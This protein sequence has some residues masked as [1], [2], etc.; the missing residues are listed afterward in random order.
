MPS[1]RSDGHRASPA[2]VGALL[3]TCVLL[4]STLRAEVVADSWSDWSSSGTQGENGWWNGYYNLTRDPG[5]TYQVRDFIPFRNTAG[6]GGGAVSPTGNHWTGSSWD[7]LGAASGPWTALGQESTHPNGTNSAPSEEHWTIRRW[8][9]DRALPG[10]EITWHMRKT[11]TNGGNGVTGILFVNGAQVDRA[12]IAG[13]DGVGVMRT[14]VRNIAVDDVIDLALTPEGPDRQRGDGSDGSAYRLTIDDAFR[15]ADGDGITDGQDNCPTVANA[16][17][18]DRDGDGA[19][20]A[21]DNCPDDANPDQRDFNRNGVGDACDA[22]VSPRAFDIA[23]NEIHY[24]PV[25]GNHLEFVEL[26]N[27]ATESIDVGGWSFTAGIRHEFP[28]NT[29]VP[30]GGYLVVCRLAEALAE[31][32]GLREDDLQTWL[33]SALDDGGERIRLVD[34]TGVVVD[35]VRYDDR[36][37]WD[38]R[39]DGGG[40]SLER[41]C[42]EADS[43]SPTNWLASPVTPPTPLAPNATTQ[44]PPP[45]LPPPAVAINE[46][47]YHPAGDRDT[48]LEYVE[49]TNTTDSA[50]DLEG[51]CFVQGIDYCFDAGEILEPGAFLVVCRNEASIRSTYGITNTAG[52]FLGQLS[53]GGERLTLVDPVGDLVDSV[54]YADS[55]NWPVGPDELGFSLEKIRPDAVSDDPASWADSG[56]VDRNV[57][58][59]GWETISVTGNATSSRLYLYIEGPGEFLLDDISLVNLADPG[60]DLISNGTFDSNISPW[61]GRGNHA[62]S[63]WS[64]AAGGQIFDEPALHLLSTGTGTGSANSVRLD[65]TPALDRSLATRYRVTFSYRHISGNSTLVCRLS[66]STPN[67]GVYFK[68]GSGAGGVVSPGE[69]NVVFGETLPPFISNI[70]RF[71]REPDSQNPV[72]ITARVRGATQ[73]RLTANL[74]GGAREFTMRDDGLNFDGLEGDGIYGVELPRQPH[75]TPVTFRIEASSPGATRLSPARSDPSEFHGY[76]VNDNQP[77]SEL[78]VYTLLVPGNPRSFVRGLNC[79]TYRTISFA[80][81]GDLYYNVGMRARGG[82]VCGSFKRFLKVKFHRGHE[83]Q[84]AGFGRVR[85]LNLQSLWTDKSLIRERMSWDVFEEMANPGFF[86]YYARIHANGS[87][88][89]LYAGYEHPDGRFLRRN[90]LNTEGNL[91]KATAS[92]EERNGTYEKKTNEHIP[93]MTDLRNFLNAL[94]DTPRSGLVNFFRQR[95][96]ADV[97]IDYQASQVLINNRDYPHKNHF[98]YHDTARGKWMPI[99]WDIDLSYGKKWDGSFG[100]VLNDRMDNPGIHP[101]YTTSVRGGGSGNHLLDKFFSQAGTYFRRAYLVRLW[102]AIHEK[103]TLE[104]YEEKISTFREL[105]FEEQLDDIRTWGRSAATAN[106]RNAPAE[107]DPNLD[108]V[109]THIRLHRNFIVNY[110]RNTERFTGH[111]RVKITE[112]MYNP[113]GTDDAEYLELWNNSGRTVDIAGWT[114]DGLGATNPDGSRSEFVFPAG[115]RVNSGEVFIVA[116]DPVIFAARNATSARVFGPYPGNL[117]NAGEALRVKDDGPGHPATVDYLAYGSRFPWSLKA[118]GFGHSLELFAVHPDIDNDRADNWRSSILRGGSPGIIHR[119]GQE[120]PLFRRGNCNADQIVDIS[121]AV[122]ILLYLFAGGQEPPCLDGCDINADGSV[123]IDDAIALLQYLF[124]PGGFTIPSPTPRQCQPASKESCESSNCV[125]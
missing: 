50:I 60:T 36:V 80:H 51:Y 81:A 73:V 99:A 33:A 46:I 90:D 117:D 44:C 98:L 16:G 29:I 121:D 94:H 68:L 71:P 88:F 113:L 114:I 18:A 75:N 1:A 48:T 35:E 41:L 83:F 13:G 104:T 34:S 102:D 58:G 37:P 22:P 4:G 5:G 69:R 54:R 24:H 101:W 59:G 30:A 109:R 39:A 47:N 87:Y 93:G 23:I 43:N 91:Y 96:D 7:L 45:T 11:N 20:D 103:Y 61:D 76:Y 120:I 116:K 64:R 14:V 38:T 86:H 70:S 112:V 119:L 53:N 49:L 110:L 97:M 6:P 25:G 72:W 55:G 118:D 107:F 27:P 40:A 8:I 66:V 62:G 92:R 111:D 82:S 15:D 89:G 84:A 2:P 9:A 78:P 21:C 122:S 63:R 108:R 10:A 17:Q 28:P 115:A 42:A 85:R 123:G 105:I 56:A 124:V 67:N 100:G 19:G 74:P 95:V 52:D 12:S 125:L 32:Y 79:S 26:Y 77:D 31:E 106:D 57:G 65:I 3:I